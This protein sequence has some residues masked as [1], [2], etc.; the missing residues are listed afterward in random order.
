MGC[1]SNID[2]RC[3]GAKTSSECVK[4]NGD[5]PVGTTI[6]TGDKPCA[7]VQDV[8]EDLQNLVS[9][10]KT[11][12]NL[13]S[14]NETCFNYNNT[15]QPPSVFEALLKHQQKIQQI[16]TAIGMPCEN[17]SQPQITCNP[18]FD[19]SV[20]C[21]N[22]NLGTMQA[23][24]GIAPANFRDLLQMMIDNINNKVNV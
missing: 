4:W 10:L 11:S 13:A 20:S 22:L 21:L 17:G 24:C 18:I 23:T 2:T 9:E 5:F 12:T 6:P 7:S 16:M 15:P 19:Q 3:S 1:G 14:L 8:V